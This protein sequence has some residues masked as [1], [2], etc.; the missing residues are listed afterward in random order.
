MSL[1][2]SDKTLFT[3][4]GSRLDLASGL[5]AG[6]CAKGCWEVVLKRWE[7]SLT[8]NH[9][10]PSSPHWLKQVCPHALLSAGYLT[11]RGP[12][13]CGRQ[14][15]WVPGWPGGV[16]EMEGRQ[17]CGTSFLHGGLAGSYG[18]SCCRISGC[19]GCA[20]ARYTPKTSMWPLLWRPSAAITA[21]VA[22]SSTRWHSC[23]RTMVTAGA[24][25]LSRG[26]WIV[27]SLGLARDHG[28]SPIRRI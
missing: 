24:W 2:C 1:L 23:S 27:I 3:K 5:F 13:W 10:C 15:R 17:V 16:R 8:Q 20:L 12:M 7:Q 28:A 19:L 18:A 21:S 4:T 9:I 22:W 11:P 14:V 6:S 26:G 25:W